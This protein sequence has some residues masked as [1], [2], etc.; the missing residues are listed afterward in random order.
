MVGGPL[1]IGTSQGAGKNKPKVYSQNTIRGPST[2]HNAGFFRKGDRKSSSS[3]TYLKMT[4]FPQQKIQLEWLSWA[5]FGF[6]VIDVVYQIYLGA[7]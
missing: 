6:G 7:C 5:L 4:A 1:G 2:C 3:I